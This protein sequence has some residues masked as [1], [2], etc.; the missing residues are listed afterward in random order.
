MTMTMVILFPDGKRQQYPNASDLRLENG[1]TSFYYQANVGNPSES[2]N[3]KVTTTLPIL[4]E[5]E[6]DAPPAHFR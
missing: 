6:V 3:R 5:E 2:A 4:V 1:L